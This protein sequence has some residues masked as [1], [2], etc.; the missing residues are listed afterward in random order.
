MSLKLHFPHSHLDFF[1]EH[2]GA[3]SDEHFKSTHQD[4]SQIE[5]GTVENGV[6][7]CFLTTAGVL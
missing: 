7:I 4:I 1:P 6:Q 5:R 2:T 3:I